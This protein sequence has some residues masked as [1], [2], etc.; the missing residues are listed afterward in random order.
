MRSLCVIRRPFVC[1][2]LGVS[3]R[4][5]LILLLSPRDCVAESHARRSATNN[6]IVVARLRMTSARRDVTTG[7]TAARAR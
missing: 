2:S 4:L 6:V 1:L 7:L 5:C 3:L